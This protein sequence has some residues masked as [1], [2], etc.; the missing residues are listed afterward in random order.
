MLS[1]Y[2]M[3]SLSFLI[4]CYNDADTV[5]RVVAEAD[6]VGKKLKIPYT[7]LVINDASADDTPLVLADLQKKYRKLA[8]LTHATNAG[9]GST[10]RELYTKAKGA[11]LFTVPGDEQIAP[12]ELLKLLPYTKTADMIIGWRINRA[13]SPAR[14]RQ[15]AIYNSLIRL[16]FGVKLHD[17]NSVR[18]MKTSIAKAVN[19]RSTS[20]F[21]DAELTIKAMRQNFRVRE[22]VISH[23]S[24]AEGTGGGGKLTTILPTIKDM[25]LFKLGCL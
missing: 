19:L 9:Y 13:D 3:L 22:V 7:I 24:R 18:L 8:V 20:A 21:V 1:N 16:L 14:L 4:P 23:R 2:H 25:I 11:W 10:I 15:S 17:V 5:G 6:G 12:K